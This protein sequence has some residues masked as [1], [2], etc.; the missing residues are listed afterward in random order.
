MLHTLANKNDDVVI[1]GV[2]VESVGMD[3]CVI[4]CD[5]RSTSHKGQ[6]TDAFPVRTGVRQGCLVSHF[7]FLLAIDWIMKQS[8]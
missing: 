6:V 7:L 4:F 3:V 1:S 8:T 5:S 2:A